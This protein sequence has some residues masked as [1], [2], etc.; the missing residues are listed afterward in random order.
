MGRREPSPRT[1][2]PRWPATKLQVATGSR[3]LQMEMTNGAHVL[4][5]GP[6]KADRFFP[7]GHSKGSVG[8]R[9]PAGDGNP[10]K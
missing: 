3:E 2:P 4:E 10:A 6:A 8:E 9:G 7:R 1:L 5:G